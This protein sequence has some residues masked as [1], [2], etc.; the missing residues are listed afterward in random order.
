M[1]ELGLVLAFALASEAASAVTVSAE[2]Q[3][4]DSWP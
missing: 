3:V 1:S 4:V 2:T